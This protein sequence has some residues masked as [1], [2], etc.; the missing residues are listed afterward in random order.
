MCKIQNENKD[1]NDMNDWYGD[2]Y[3]DDADCWC[4]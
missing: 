4:E 3:D 1:E 2:Y